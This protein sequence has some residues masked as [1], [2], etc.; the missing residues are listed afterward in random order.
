MTRTSGA[1]DLILRPLSRHSAGQP[2]C[3]QESGQKNS[4]GRVDVADPDI[5]FIAKPVAGVRFRPLANVWADGALAEIEDP[6]PW[7]A[8]ISEDDLAMSERR[9]EAGQ[10][11]YP[12]G[13]LRT[14]EFVGGT[15]RAVARDRDATGRRDWLESNTNRYVQVLGCAGTV[16]TGTVESQTTGDLWSYKSEE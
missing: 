13:Q 10:A 3:I 4:I 5:C 8:H 15:V 9:I 2:V 16:W 14:R 7:Q 11:S 1:T 6:S 12:R